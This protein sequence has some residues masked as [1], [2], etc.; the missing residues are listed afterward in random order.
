MHPTREQMQVIELLRLYQSLYK[1]REFPP[2][3]EPYESHQ[4]GHYILSFQV[5]LEPLISGK[6]EKQQKTS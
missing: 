6:S 1:D 5:N 4:M 2:S 3:W